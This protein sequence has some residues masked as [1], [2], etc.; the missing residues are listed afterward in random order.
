[1][2]TFDIFGAED[3]AAR[4]ADLLAQGAPR[5]ARLDPDG[6]PLLSPPV[7]TTR[8]R[9]DGVP[10]AGSAL[11]VYGAFGTPWSKPL[12]HVLAAARERHLIVWRHFPDADAHPRA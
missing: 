12:Q 7:A 10:M 6:R 9:F 11:V 1:M 3:A 8:D 4:L 5:A 2:D